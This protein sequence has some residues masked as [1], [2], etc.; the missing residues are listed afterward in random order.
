MAALQKDAGVIRSLFVTL[1][2]G[3]AGKKESQVS[4]VKSLGLHHREQCVEKPNNSSIRGA[5]DKVKH[6]VRVETDVEYHKR[7]S[8]ERQRLAWKPPVRVPH[9]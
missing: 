2:R 6:L 3:F 5:L 1:K 4:I 8:L 9:Q 7:M